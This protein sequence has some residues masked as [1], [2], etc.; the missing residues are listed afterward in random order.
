M[1]IKRRKHPYK[2]RHE[3]CCFAGV[4]FLHNTISEQI[5]NGEWALKRRMLELSCLLLILVMLP[6][7]MKKATVPLEAAPVESSGSTGDMVRAETPESEEEFRIDTVEVM[8]AGQQYLKDENGNLYHAETMNRVPFQLGGVRWVL[9]EGKY[10]V[11]N[12]GTLLMR[13]STAVDGTL[14]VDDY[15]IVLEHIQEVKSLGDSH[16]LYM[17]DYSE[18]ALYSLGQN[19]N[20]EL[21]T[22]SI[23]DEVA[24]PYLLFE[25]V[26]AYSY[27]Y[28][29][30][31]DLA[32]GVFRAAAIKDGDVYVWGNENF[33]T[34]T[35]YLWEDRNITSLEILPEG[36]RIKS[37][38]EV[39]AV[40]DEEGMS[41][42]TYHPEDIVWDATRG[43]SSGNIANGAYVT[44]KDGEVYFSQFGLNRYIPGET[45]YEH[46]EKR[47]KMISDLN[48][49][50]D[51]IVYIHALNNHLTGDRIG[52]IHTYPN[53]GMLSPNS[54]DRDLNV[55]GDEVYWIY[56][57]NASLSHRGTEKG[58]GHIE[59]TDENGERIRAQAM[60][61]AVRKVYMDKPSD[62]IFYILR[63]HLYKSDFKG[64]NP[65]KL[66]D[67]VSQ[68]QYSD[69]WIYFERD[70]QLTRYAVDTGT[71]EE[72]MSLRGVTS[73]NVNGAYVY[74]T[75][76]DNVFRKKLGA[77]DEPKK[78]NVNP[79]YSHTELKDMAILP[80]GIYLYDT[81]SPYHLTF[82]GHFV[83]LRKLEKID[84]TKRR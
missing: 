56:R 42:Y 29:N 23:G 5:R 25:D 58:R 28:A 49:W 6:A 17:D 3:M 36:V 46:L 71:E 73:Y 32:E 76:G 78:L 51:H 30:E 82:E 7:C 31:F 33:L 84:S 21:G 1:R 80:S 2:V 16:L 61:E 44:E 64:N 54:I 13:K 22:G 15:D 27:E 67:D 45:T 20:G 81:L 74:Y 43:N 34:P 10:L 47:E 68:Y 19:P 70:G 50:G 75:D 4:L 55:L 62:T 66:I 69:G 26:G 18:R 79:S 83:E 9:S 24:M 72:V 8:I 63:G 41:P 53:K 11:L 60:I 14:S 12:Q 65:T 59:F 39:V 48:V 37:D 52:Y 40:I 35:K 38:N 57:L 77:A